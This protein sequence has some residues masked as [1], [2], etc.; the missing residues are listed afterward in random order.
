MYPSSLIAI[1]P[2]KC[3][4]ESSWK[5]NAAFLQNHILLCILL[6]LYDENN[7]LLFGSMLSSNPCCAA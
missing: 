6:E 4:I 3:N 1:V 5:I 2:Q 7:E